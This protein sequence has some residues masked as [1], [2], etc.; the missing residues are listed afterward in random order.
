[1]VTRTVDSWELN[2]AFAVVTQ[3]ATKELGIDPERVNLM[4][5]HVH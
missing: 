3:I 2:E 4:A 5:E 1:M